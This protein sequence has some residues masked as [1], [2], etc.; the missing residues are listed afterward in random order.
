MKRILITIFYIS[1]KKKYDWVV[2]DN[3][4]FNLPVFCSA[5]LWKDV[6]SAKND[7]I[8]E[9]ASKDYKIDFEVI[10]NE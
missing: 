9:L 6:I 1:D 2:T 4:G 10:G 3:G 5:H 8:E 7:A